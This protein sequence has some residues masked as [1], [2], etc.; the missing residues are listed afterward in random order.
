MGQG[1]P[2]CQYQ[3]RVILGNAAG[4]SVALFA[5]LASQNNNS[6]DVGDDVAARKL[7][8]P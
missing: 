8:Y 5:H 2:G 1:D 6:L 7:R 3:G 4:I